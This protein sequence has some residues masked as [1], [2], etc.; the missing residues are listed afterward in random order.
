MSTMPDCV[1]RKQKHKATA[2]SAMMVF[3]IFDDFKTSI[4]LCIATR[5]EWYVLWTVAKR[6][7]NYLMPASVHLV[8]QGL[9]RV[10]D[11]LLDRDGCCSVREWWEEQSPVVYHHHHN[12]HH[13]NIIPTVLYILQC[14]QTQRGVWRRYDSG[15]MWVVVLEGI[16][17]WVHERR[18]ILSGLTWN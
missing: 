16:A 3:Y 13:V 8:Q 9:T 10:H 6:D 7:T 17:M 11:L 5:E 1:Q 2:K 12:H 18:L 4:A 14:Y 15:V